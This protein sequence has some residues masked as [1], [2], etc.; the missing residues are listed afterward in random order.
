[1]LRYCSQSNFLPN[2][3]VLAD[4]VQKDILSLLIEFPIEQVIRK[5][6][7]FDI[8]GNLSFF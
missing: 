6:P 3:E 1:M 8:P 5:S 2:S 7:V 4:T